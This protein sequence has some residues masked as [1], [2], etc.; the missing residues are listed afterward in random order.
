MIYLNLTMLYCLN[1][2]L[3][4]K[5]YPIFDKLNNSYINHYKPTCKKHKIF[6]IHL[7]QYVE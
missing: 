1:L 7:L 6:Y 2:S 3:W 5:K 4:F